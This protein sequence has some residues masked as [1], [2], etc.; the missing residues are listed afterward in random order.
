MRLWDEFDSSEFQSLS[1]AD[2]PFKF[3]SFWLSEASN[4]A[5]KKFVMYRTW[6]L[7]CV[8]IQKI[9]WSVCL[10]ATCIYRLGTRLNFFFLGN[11]VEKYIVTI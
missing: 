4:L 2:N 5:K 8:L 6:D 3:V 1:R 11:F 7:E 9:S 10:V